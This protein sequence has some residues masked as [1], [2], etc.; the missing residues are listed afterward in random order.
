MSLSGRWRGQKVP[1]KSKRE[2]PMAPAGRTTPMNRYLT[3]TYALSGDVRASQPSLPLIQ[4]NVVVVEEIR[5]HERIDNVS[6]ALQRS[7]SRRQRSRES[8]LCQNSSSQKSPMKED[9]SMGH[10]LLTSD[11]T[12]HFRFGS[13]A[14]IART[15]VQD[16]NGSY[17]S[18]GERKPYPSHAYRN[19]TSAAFRSVPRFHDQ[20]VI[21]ARD[22]KQKSSS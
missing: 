13:L 19:T 21:F 16:E 7:R 14:R 9:W 5:H 22:S 4:T 12:T 15:A 11:P 2:N 18:L 17:G 6:G 8:R 3:L 1:S 10:E 20:L